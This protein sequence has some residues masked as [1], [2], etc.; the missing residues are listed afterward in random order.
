M[1]KECLLSLAPTSL[2]LQHHCLPTTESSH[3]YTG[4]LAFL[5]VQLLNDG[6]TRATFNIN[7]IMR[8][9]FTWKIFK[10]VYVVCF[11]NYFSYFI[12]SIVAKFHDQIPFLTSSQYGDWQSSFIE[13]SSLCDCQPML[14]SHSRAHEMETIACQ[15]SN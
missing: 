7:P 14:K 5:I 10:P 12:N 15:V 8:G 3:V 11:I 13:T 4:K 9:I 1:Y 2:H 6:L